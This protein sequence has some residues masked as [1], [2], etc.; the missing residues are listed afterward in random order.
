MRQPTYLHLNNTKRGDPAG[1]PQEF[2]NGK[3]ADLPVLQLLNAEEQARALRPKQDKGYCDARI[4]SKSSA[5]PTISHER[6]YELRGVSGCSCL[7]RSR[8]QLLADWRT[9]KTGAG[10]LPLVAHLVGSAAPRLR[11]G[12]RGRRAEAPADLGVVWE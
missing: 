10:F 4:T 3:G 1:V 7:W 11:V 9:W 5:T 12:G 8:R 2:Q 6:L